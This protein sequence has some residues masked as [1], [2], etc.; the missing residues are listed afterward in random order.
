MIRQAYEKDAQEV[1]YLIHLAIKD[2]AEALTG[3]TD[4]VSIR[5]ELAYLFLQKNNRLSYQNSIVA[6]VNG[7]IAGT[8]I[9]YS[10]DDASLLDQA[11]MERLKR[12]K[13]NHV[14]LDKEADRGDYYID[15]VAVHPQYR[16]KGIGTE[17]IHHAEHAAGQYGFSK[18]SL[19]VAHDNV[20]AKQLYQR[21]GYEEE[22]IKQINGHPYD[23]MIK[24]VQH[25]EGIKN[26]HND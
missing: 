15:T 12:K 14:V 2:I 19:N 6:E 11:I 10:G 5:K 4:L 9:A 8:L 20:R 17:L 7:E 21:L 1:A 18:V 24:Y 13:Q 16:G 25:K 22:K 26:E 3:E 23:Y